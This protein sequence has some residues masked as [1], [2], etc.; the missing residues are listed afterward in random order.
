M[1]AVDHC[2]PESDAMRSKTFQATVRVPGSCG[3]LIQGMM[4]GVYFHVT[5]PVDMYSEVEV[6]LSQDIQGIEHSPQRTKAAQAVS[7]T[8]AFLHRSNLG[9]RLEIKSPIPVGKGMAS[10]TA[11]VAGAIVATSMALGER[12]DPNDVAR[13]ALSIEPTDGT[14]F[15]GIVA[16]DHRQGRICLALGEAPPVEIV[17]LDFG[18][19]VD[20]VRFNQV[21]R[22]PALRALEPEIREAFEL[23]RE[24]IHSANLELVGRGATM[25]T[26][27]N[28]HLL[29]KPEIEKVIALAREVGALG[30]NTAHSGTV[31]GI[32]LDKHHHQARDVLD[33]VVA[34][35]PALER[36]FVCSLTGGGVQEVS[37]S[38]T[39]RPPTPMPGK[40]PEK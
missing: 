36:A 30:V 15:P 12:L 23:V 37:F 18:G 34:R 7:H 33:F 28:Q 20:T 17:V 1:P 6:K 2:S 24:G 25:S 38:S 32:L 35:L 16:F 29:P 27:V 13:I 19:E 26:R 11:D 22:T 14:I 9:A 39:F 40:S 3:E 4:D 5:C 8:L 21:D 31:S 10:S